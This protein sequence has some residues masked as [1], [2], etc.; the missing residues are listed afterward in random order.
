M[1]ICFLFQE[2]LLFTRCFLSTHDQTKTTFYSLTP[3]LRNNYKNLRLM[4]DVFVCL[5]FPALLTGFCYVPI[6]RVLLN[7]DRDE[8][9]NRRLVIA[10]FLNWLCWIICWTL[11]YVI[12]SLAAG[13]ADN[14][15][16]KVASD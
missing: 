10:M 4:W 12:M 2:E 13:Y 5:A 1:S 15:S 9:R 6:F 3:P 8:D 14:F 11:Y 16:L 7:R